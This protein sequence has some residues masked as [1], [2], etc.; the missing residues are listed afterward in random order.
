MLLDASMKD[1]FNVAR[2]LRRQQ[3]PSTCLSYRG[4]ITLFANQVDINLYD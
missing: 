1:N 4:I 2:M 3:S